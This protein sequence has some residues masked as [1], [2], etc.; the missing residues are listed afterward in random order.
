MF[1]GPAAS[2]AECTVREPAPAI[3]AEPRP[4]RLPAHRSSSHQ[5]C[6]QEEPPTGRQAA[7]LAFQERRRR[8]TAAA[9][10]IQ[11]HFRGMLARRELRVRQAAAQLQRTR[12]RLVLLCWRQRAAARGRLRQRASQPPAA[13]ALDGAAVLA[14][15]GPGGLAAAHCRL[16]RLAAAW[17]AWL[18]GWA[19]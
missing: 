14:A 10:L 18:Q 11:V 5:G 7:F 3:S 4:H 15:D 17:S 1:K 8:R 2:S 12:V 19:G 16:R 6:A 9:A 13:A